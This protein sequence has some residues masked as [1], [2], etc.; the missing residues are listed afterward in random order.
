MRAGGRKAAR[1]L[2]GRRFFSEKSF[3]RL[4]EVA[5]A[6]H[7]AK[8]LQLGQR[9]GFDL[10]DALAGDAELPADLFEGARLLAVK[11]ET[12]LDDLALTVREALEDLRQLLP[13][14]ISSTASTGVTASSSSMKSPSCESSS[15]PTG[16]SRLTGSW[17][18]LMI[19]R[20]F[21]GVVPISAAISSAVG[22]RP[23]LACSSRCTRISLLICSTM[24]TGTRIVR[25]W[26]A[27]ARE[28]A[29]RIHQ[30]A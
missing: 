14:M 9:L 24:C 29:W 30:V 1:P 4:I 20:T 5:Q 18:I 26:S 25:A 13:L 11:A 22:S 28:I 17:L 2:V 10:A 15:S 27:M 6:G 8:A 12:Q 21:C 23:R 19:S 3:D 7:V 16:V